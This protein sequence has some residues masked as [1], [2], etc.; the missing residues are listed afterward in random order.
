MR[1]KTT[2]RLASF[3]CS[4]PSGR[5]VSAIDARVVRRFEQRLE[6]KSADQSAGAR[7]Q[8]DFWCCA[9]APKLNKIRRQSLSGGV[10]VS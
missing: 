9:H 10:G 5:R 6:E 1:S 7:D 2:M 3:G 4:L 8:R